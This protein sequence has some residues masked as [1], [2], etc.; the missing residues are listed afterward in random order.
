MGN[1][2]TGTDLAIDVGKNY[3][4]KLKIYGKT[5][6][7]TRSGKN[8]IDFI[9]I[10]SG[11]ET[12]ATQIENGV[13]AQG[14]WY[15][16]YPI[17][18]VSGTWSVSYE[19]KLIEGTSTSSTGTWRIIYADGTVSN[20]FSSGKNIEIT[21]ETKSIL[22][23]TSNGTTSTSVDFTNIQLEEGTTVTSYEPYGVS[24]SPEFPS[25]I[26]NV[27][28]KNL[29]DY[30]KATFNIANATK[31]GDINN[32]Y[33]YKGNVS[34]ATVVNA[35]SK[36]QID[37]SGWLLRANTQ[38][39]VSFDAVIITS[40][41]FS[42][43]LGIGHKFSGTDKGNLKNITISTTKA[44]Y[45]LNISSKTSD[46]T[47]YFALNSNEVQ[48]TNIC[49]TTDGTT[50]YV[51]YNTLAVKVT[52]KNLFNENAKL[53]NVGL[54]WASGNT[55]S[56]NG[57]VVSEY[58][59]I[60]KLQNLYSNYHFCAFYYDS[61]K[62][63]LGN[64]PT[65]STT[66]GSSSLNTVV[67][68]NNN[69]A[70]IRVTW[71]T[72]HNN[73]TN[74]TTIP[75]IMLTKTEEDLIPYEP[76]KE[77]TVYFPLAEGQ[78]LME[79]SYLADDGVHNKR[80]QVVLDGIES[81][82]QNQTSE[83]F[84]SFYLNMQSYE[85]INES[86]VWSH[87]KQVKIWNEIA[88]IE[89]ENVWYH[90][91]VSFGIKILKSRLSSS[92]INGFK[93]WL[94][95]NPITVEY[96]LAN[97]ETDGV[98]QYT[99]EQQEAWNQIQN[100]YLFE[101]KNYINI[102]SLLN[103]EIELKYLKIVDEDSDFY[104]SENGRLVIP[105]Y[106]INYLIDFSASNIPSMPEAM[107][108]S[109]R[110]V[111]RDG[112]V[113]LN[114]TYEPMNFS[115]VCYTDDNLTPDE[116]VREEQKINRFMDSIKNKTKVLGFERE[117]KFYDVKYNGVLTTVRFPAHVQFTIPVKSSE[118]YAKDLIKKRIQGNGFENSETIKEVGAVFTIRGPAQTPK[119]SFNNYE[120][121]YD[122]VL[123]E[124]T[125]LI[126]DSG[127]S[128]ITHVNGVTGSKTNAMRYYNHQFPKVK[129]GENVLVVNSGI[130][131]A[132]QVKVEWNDLKL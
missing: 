113:V 4:G 43:N 130:D 35:Y 63:Y 36:G 12:V 92:D 29:F 39:T 67:P 84:M 117:N 93:Q 97:P 24:P 30:E 81:W 87:F 104:I 122:N 100:I 120:M 22:F 3:K 118:S 59:P 70:Y 61:N 72:I 21:Q 108:A 54:A 45:N 26:E 23:Y 89:E 77:Q 132:S 19:Y 76:Y 20:H 32:G 5:E 124:N 17:K 112:D 86:S 34:D 94:S 13:N 31:M 101:G 38:Y 55:F 7:E 14:T 42:S 48:I 96:E 27:A 121:F 74:M 90:N 85:K 41:G 18:L 123:L 6:Q 28:G 56:E 9:K 99:E 115:I 25:E 62:V 52:G 2:I 1:V 79:G 110:I 11:P 57:S 102:I 125:K 105:E 107:E 53:D 116:K 78:K 15:V 8:K 103:P 80:T 131:D 129:Y 44:R 64:G 127:K 49:I 58:L 109:V 82:Y 114:T 71:R 106:D 98:I 40:G 75:D 83:N 37:I 91:N 33:W 50:E 16:E 95:Q 69:I 60:G 119:I 65:L 88:S 66:G 111:G 10:I 68:S 47:I 46:Y 128:T 51:P 126:I 73:S